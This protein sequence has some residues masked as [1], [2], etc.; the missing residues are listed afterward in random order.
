[1]KTKAEA[2]ERPEF[3]D[4]WEHGVEQAVVYTAAPGSLEL[5]VRVKHSTGLWGWA[6]RRFMTEKQFRRWANKANLIGGR[7]E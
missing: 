7:Y 1:M 3:G 5:Q 2:I 4:I 6:V